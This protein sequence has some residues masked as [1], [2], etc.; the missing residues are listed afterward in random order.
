M[1]HKAMQQQSKIAHLLPRLLLQLGLGGRQAVGQDA[2]CAGSRD[3]GVKPGVRSRLRQ[4]KGRG[5]GRGGLVWMSQAGVWVQAVSEAG[6]G[7]GR[8]SGRGGLV[9]GESGRSLG[10]GRG[11]GGLR[12]D[13][14]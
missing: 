14:V 3:A 1:P 9:M 5:S 12:Q 7:R 13:Q 11:L 10:S 6:C 2:L 8:G 4:G